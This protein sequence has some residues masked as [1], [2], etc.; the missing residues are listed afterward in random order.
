MKKI[1]VIILSILMI[2]PVL[3]GCSKVETYV[4][5]KEGE[6]VAANLEETLKTSPF[7]SMGTYMKKGDS[8]ITNF[9]DNSDGTVSVGVYAK[10]SGVTSFVLVIAGDSEST[11]YY[12][13]TDTRSAYIFKYTD[14]YLKSD[15][16]K[17]R[18]RIFSDNYRD[19]SEYKLYWSEQMN[20]SEVMSDYS[21]MLDTF[22]L[23]TGPQD[24][25]I[26]YDYRLEYNMEEN[27]IAYYSFIR[28]LVTFTKNYSENEGFTTIMRLPSVD[29]NE[30]TLN[31]IENG[32]LSEDEVL[33]K[34][35]TILNYNVIK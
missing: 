31:P 3:S 1:F 2:L 10:V 16:V 20:S 8:V 19:I 14:K 32:M 22:A 34:V 28:P 4:K 29:F 23:S 30:S 7:L 5:L 25:V 17:L 26:S 21:F 9:A 24:G 27:F 35:E 13:P 18:D 15:I 6:K 12:R 11:V 33:E